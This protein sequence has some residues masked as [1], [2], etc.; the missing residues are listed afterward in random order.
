MI[1]I[2]IPEIQKYHNLIK[3]YEQ[4]RIN[5]EDFERE[6]ETLRKIILK[7]TKEKLNNFKQEKLL[8]IKNNVDNKKQ[9]KN[10]NYTEI[11]ELLRDIK[12]F[13][14]ETREYKRM[15]YK[16]YYGEMK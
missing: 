1:K 12:D 16:Q 13:F 7:S 9:S 6:S 10:K 5:D 3:L 15:L 4:K 2:T 14:Y 11:K 8:T